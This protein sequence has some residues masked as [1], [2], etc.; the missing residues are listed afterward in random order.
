MRRK[1]YV[2]TGYTALQFKQREIIYYTYLSERN[3][4]EYDGGSLD[5][6]LVGVEVRA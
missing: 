6:T 5:I 2:V 3:S 1:I 4:H